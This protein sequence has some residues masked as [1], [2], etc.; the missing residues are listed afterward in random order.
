[1]LGV[2]RRLL[3]S[4]EDAEDAC[5]AT[6]LVLARKAGSQRWQPSIAGWLYATAR[7]VAR[8]ARVTALRRVRREGEAAVPEAG[9]PGGGMTA[10]RRRAAVDEGLERLP[11]RCGA[12]LVLC[13]LQGLTRGEAAV[14]LG[15]TT[16]TL[17]TQLERGRK[18]LAL[19]LA[20]R[21]CALGAGL[22]ALAVTSPA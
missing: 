9:Q 15:I 20:K 12:P 1:V 11:P 19:A 22:L 21:G 3:P 13:Y 8:N 6:F 10:R 16:A 14:R 4:A 5:Q 18:K 7:R 17:K 2:C